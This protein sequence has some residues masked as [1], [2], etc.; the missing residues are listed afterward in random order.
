MREVRPGV[1]HWEGPHPEW[2]ESEPWDEQV[3]SYAID[4]GE[5]VLLFDPIAPPPEIDELAAGRETVIVLTNA[6]H[7]RDARSLVERLGAPV[8]VPPPDEGSSDVA[9]L[10]ADGEGEAHLYLP[11]DEL[12]PGVDGAF[13]GREPND[14]IL[15]VESMRAVIPGDTIVDF[16][17]G[18]EIPPVWLHEGVTREQMAETLSPLLDLPVEHVLPTHGAPTGRDALERALS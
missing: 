12:P 7:E 15:W 9:W 11:G 6:W 18:L 10:L 13:A 3:S 16:G 8:W 1:W 17:D 14:L 2:D 5:R 4:D